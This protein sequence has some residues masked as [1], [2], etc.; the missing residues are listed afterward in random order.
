MRASTRLTESEK[1]EG[2]GS[3]PAE[4]RRR[5]RQVHTVADYDRLLQ[6]L[7]VTDDED[8]APERPLL[9]RLVADPRTI[10]EEGQVPVAGRSF[11]ILPNPA[12]NTS[13]S[14]HELR[15][16][17]IPAV[18]LR[19][20][21]SGTFL[22]RGR[23]FEFRVP[24]LPAR[25]FSDR[26]VVL[27]EGAGGAFRK[28]SDSNPDAPDPKIQIRYRPEKRGKPVF[29]VWGIARRRERHHV[30]PGGGFAADSRGLAA[31]EDAAQSC[32]RSWLRAIA[33]RWPSRWARTK[34]SHRF[35]LRRRRKG[36]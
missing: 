30:S 1:L 23:N 13:V 12:F 18:S 32:W 24:N 7:R 28:V 21:A 31:Q 33:W 11:Q 14:F 36:P 17:D 22:I 26:T 5:L 34:C 16:E 27:E 8:R 15:K 25:T 20:Q 4:F 6:W 3:N 35:R 10:D 9:F 19:G 2:V 29:A